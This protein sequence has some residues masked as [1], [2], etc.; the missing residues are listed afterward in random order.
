MGWSPCRRPCV[1]V[2][3]GGADNR[4]HQTYVEHVA[5]PMAW[6]T[7]VNQRVKFNPREFGNASSA[8]GTLTS[9]AYD[10]ARATVAAQCTPLS[11]DQKFDG[12]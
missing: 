1:V 12:N 3:V 6:R 11:K 7:A 4:W 9:V 10:E 2:N 5:P 8:V